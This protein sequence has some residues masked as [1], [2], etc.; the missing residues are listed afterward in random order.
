MPHVNSRAIYSPPG[1]LLYVA[2]GALLAQP[3]DLKSLS[4]SG[5][6]LTIAEQVGNFSGT[7]NAYFSVSVDGE[8]LP[9][10]TA[11]SKSR[12]VLLDENGSERAAV[13]EP[14]SFQFRRGIVSMT[15]HPIVNAS[16]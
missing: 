13:G 7:G 2:D 6:R 1:Y 16:S 15:C 5:E 8:V 10:A 4:F 9:Y 11:G 3:F 12:L 14:I